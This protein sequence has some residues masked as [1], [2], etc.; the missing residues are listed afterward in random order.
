MKALR[1]SILILSGASALSLS[2][3]GDGYEAVPFRGSVPYTEERTAGSGVA[4]VR[5]MM[6]P[7]KGPILEPQEI[8]P[9]QNTDTVIEDAAP[10]FGGSQLKK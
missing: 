3:C 8:L 2:A 5:K 10:L 9:E 1:A 6:L 4:Y 7:E